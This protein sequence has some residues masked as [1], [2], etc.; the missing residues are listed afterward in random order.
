MRRVGALGVGLGVCVGYGCLVGASV[1]RVGSWAGLVRRV[2][3][4]WCGGGSGGSVG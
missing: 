3:G 2:R 4:G 1:W